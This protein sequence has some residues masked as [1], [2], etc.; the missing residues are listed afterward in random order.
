M[1]RNHIGLDDLLVVLVIGGDVY[2]PAYLDNIYINN[3][4]DQ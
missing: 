2:A 3:N 1:I 4:D